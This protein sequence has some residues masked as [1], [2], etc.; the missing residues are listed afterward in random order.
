[1]E[2]TKD[3]VVS[4]SLVDDHLH[5]IVLCVI[6]RV[7]LLSRAILLAVRPLAMEDVRPAHRRPVWGRKDLMRLLKYH[8]EQPVKHKTGAHPALWEGSFFQD[9]VGARNLATVSVKLRRTIP[10]FKKRYAYQIVGLPVEETDAETGRKT[11]KVITPAPDEVVFEAGACRLVR[12]TGVSLL[13]GPDFT[14]KR[15]MDLL[16][17]RVVAQLG[18]LAGIPTAEL[19]YALK[20]TPGSV[21]RLRDPHVDDAWTKAVRVRLALEDAVASLPL[22]TVGEPVEPVS[23][24]DGGFDTTDGGGPRLVTGGHRG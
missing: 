19:A 3:D 18:S 22:V 17:K 4:Y 1:L 16:A 2:I 24:K 5:L 10:R 21:R 8:L 14:S 9:L 7:A 20:T 13:V 12:A 23:D 15:P 11:N 6:A